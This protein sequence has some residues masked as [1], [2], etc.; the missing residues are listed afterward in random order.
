LVTPEQR[1]RLE[2]NL[3]HEEQKYEDEVKKVYAEL[4][5][6]EIYL[7]QEKESYARISASIAKNSHLV[8]P[9]IFTQILDKIQLRPK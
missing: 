9:A 6:P 3:G 4:N 5:L 8:P 7:K 1:A 2:A